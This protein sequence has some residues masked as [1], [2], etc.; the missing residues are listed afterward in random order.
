M[1]GG[2][3]LVGFN[4]SLE[5]GQRLRIV[6]NSSDTVV[7]PFFCPVTV[8]VSPLNLLDPLDLERVV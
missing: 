4:L 3:T 7:Q 8:N 2:P 1:I 6:E 5:Q